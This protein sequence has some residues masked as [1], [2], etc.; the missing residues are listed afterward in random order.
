MAAGISRFASSYK[1][2]LD[3]D[4][5]SSNLLSAFKTRRGYYT[6]KYDLNFITLLIISQVMA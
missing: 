4:E 6:V 5:T 1:H 2:R 3:D